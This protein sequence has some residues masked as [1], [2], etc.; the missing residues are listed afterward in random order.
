R[1]LGE[2][3]RKPER[4]WSV[5]IVAL[6]T[7]IGALGIIF[8]P[9][10]NFEY[11]LSRLST[12]VENDRPKIDIHRSLHGTARSPVIML[13]DDSE[14]LEDAANGLRERYPEGLIQDGPW[15][16]TPRTFVPPNQEER[17]AS[18]AR[19]REEVQRAERH[20]DGEALERI[21][22]WKPLV[23]IDEPITARSLPMWVQETFAERDGSFG[24][25]GIVYP[26]GASSDARQMEERAAMMQSWREA[27]PKVRFASLGAILGEITS[28]LRADAPVIIGLALIG[29]LFGTLL[30]GR[31][32][33]RTA[34]VLTPVILA[35][36]M[37][38]LVM[39]IFDIRI[40]LYN[41]VIFP[42]AFGIGVDGAIYIVWNVRQNKTTYRWSE[43]R[44]SARA[45]LGSTL[46]TMAAFGSLLISNNPGLA[47]LGLLSIVTLAATLAVNLLFV[48]AVLSLMD[49]RRKAR[50]GSESP[51]NR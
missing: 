34:L 13:A 4:K 22:R 18:L 39:A 46:T 48:P 9:R 11:R 42:M 35:L 32:P 10:V 14:A 37:S 29:L 15:L 23:S 33:V 50:V 6:A 40:N 45:V 16:V 31:S 1:I 3:L 41:L 8:L 21:E 26:G 47:S 20:S 43:L 27:F 5:S 38:L 19:L 7:V 17:L 12:K 28:G 25:V 36:A 2:L 51:V 44:V 49:S 24:T 30:V